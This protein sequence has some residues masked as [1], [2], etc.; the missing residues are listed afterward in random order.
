VFKIKKYLT[1]K[2]INLYLYIFLC[3]IGFGACGVLEQTSPD[4]VSNEKVFE[5]ADGFRAARSGMYSLMGNENYYGGFYALALDAHSDNGTTG[6][7]DV[8]S[9]NEI[10]EKRL[11]P[12]NLFVE[13]IWISLYATANAA[14]QILDNIDQLKAEDFDENEK[15]NIKG[16]ALFVRALVHFDAL[17]MFG[18]HWNQNS[19]YGI[20]LAIKVQ[21]PTDVLARASVKNTYGQIADDL[22]NAEQL[23]SDD[24]KKGKI[25]ITKSAVNALFARVC[26]FAKDYKNATFYAN[27]V[28]KTSKYSL[29]DSVD[30]SK[31]YSARESQESIFELK[32][33]VQ[34]RSAYNS[35]TYKRADATR[36]ELSFFPS[37]Q[38]DSFFQTRKNDVRAQTVDFKNNDVT[39]QPDGRSQKYRGENLQDNPAYV[40]RYAE[41]I[42]IMAE[43]K[44][45]PTGLVEL[46]TLR[47]KRGLSILNNTT[48]KNDAEFKAVLLDE[49]RAEFN[50][51]GSRFTDLA[52]FELVNKVLGTDVKPVFPIP[53]REVLATNGVLK[54]YP[55]Y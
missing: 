41:M 12:S 11:T 2:K 13:R 8:E 9:L 7:Y 28:I 27:E 34:N 36:P 32:F 25:Y 42:L 4:I 33:D 21:R 49:R 35:L 19:E 30:F 5:T 20:P 46:N 17:K 50:M 44:G 10:G 48:V 45:Y 29:Y 3:S 38:L 55:G 54:Q 1:M 15:N 39:I 6:G 26:I 14:N 24:G 40:L 47:Q 16:E 43:A 18:E 53:L 31:L 23:V 51:E 52:R 37:A 22:R